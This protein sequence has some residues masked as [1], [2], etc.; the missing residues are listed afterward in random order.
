M[1]YANKKQIAYVVLIG[2]EEMKTG[3]FAVKNMQS[4]RQQLCT[5]AELL[6]IVF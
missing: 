2:D 4:G 5:E 6:E 3:K 1:E